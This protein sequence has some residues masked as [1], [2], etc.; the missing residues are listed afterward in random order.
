MQSSEM[1]AH[2]LYSR[3]SS[4]A[5]VGGAE[6]GSRVI[7]DH[8]SNVSREADCVGPDGHCRNVESYSE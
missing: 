2:L 8:R 5:S 6:W 7:E 3:N 4:K 1:G